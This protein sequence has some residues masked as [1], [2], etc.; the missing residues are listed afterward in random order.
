MATS[1]KRSHHVLPHSVPP[2]L[3]QATPNTRLC[4]RLLDTHGQVW[5]SL[6]WNHCFF[7][8][9]PDV[10]KVLLVFPRVCFPV[11]YKFLWLCGRF[12]GD[13]LQEGLYHVQVCCTQS[14]CPFD[15]P[16]LT[17]TYSG[18]IQTQFSLSLCGVSGSWFSQGWFEP[19]E[20]L[21][22]VWGLILI[23]ISSP[24]PSC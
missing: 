21:W 18:D 5:V 17:C 7:L 9:G 3:Q 15:S 19:S 4:W 14:P 1:F 23:M 8:L 13:F 10:H 12:N 6:L 16:L 24:L 2:T 22:C 20:H 11:L